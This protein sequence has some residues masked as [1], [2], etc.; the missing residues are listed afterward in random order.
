MKH[1]INDEE[2][3]CHQGLEIGVL[4]TSDICDS[5]QTIEPADTNVVLITLSMKQ[6]KLPTLNTQRNNIRTPGA[7]AY[8]H[9]QGL[10]PNNGMSNALAMDIP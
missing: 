4:I 3:D 10:V 7:G 8:G 9:I 5:R 1:Q 6:D 2:T